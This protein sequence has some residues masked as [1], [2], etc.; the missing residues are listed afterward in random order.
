MC[1][2][3]PSLFYSIAQLSGVHGLAPK[4]L[5]LL[6]AALQ[7]RPHAYMYTCMRLPCSSRQSPC[8]KCF[9][10]RA[11]PSSHKKTLPCPA[12]PFPCSWGHLLPSPNTG[13]VVY[14][15][16]NLAIVLCSV[17]T[18]STITFCPFL[19]LLHMIH[20]SVEQFNSKFTFSAEFSFSNRILKE[21]IQI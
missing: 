11:H 13:P 19:L 9:P 3:T 5:Y 4:I 7:H 21:L 17:F 15:M 1:E 18:I 14:P 10:H 6:R 8:A 12:T 16:T 20:R 2:D